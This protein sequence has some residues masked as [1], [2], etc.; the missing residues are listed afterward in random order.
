[1]FFNKAVRKHLVII[2]I[3]ISLGALI[4]YYLM[5]YDPEVRRLFT[6]VEILVSVSLGIIIAYVNYAAAM[7]LD[8]LIP[9]QSQTTNRLL[10]GVLTHFFTGLSI[11]I[12]LFY[13]YDLLVLSQ[14]N[15]VEV[16]KPMIIK[17]AI[18]WFIIVQLFSV[19]Y[20]ALYSYYSYS[21]LQIQ[22]V[23]LERK[24]IDLQLNALKSQLSPHFLFNSLNTISSLIYK[25]LN[26]A[27]TFIRRLAKMYHYTL[28]SYHTKLVSFQEELDF[29]NS[30]IYLQ[31]T[32]F[33]KVFK[34]K[35]DLPSSIN[36]TKIPPLALQMLIENA[37]KH[38][39]MSE[40]NPLTVNITFEDEHIC[41]QNNITEEPRKVPSFKI[42]LKN[43]SERYQL[44]FG[45]EII[46]ANSQS[47]IVK[48]PVI[49]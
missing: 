7:K 13:L 11:A 35:I 5:F 47:F 8:K 24:Q 44:L 16:Y 39:L 30:Y 9:W 21:S 42:G 29:V 40:K 31:E 17:F 37:V 6:I 49:R 22:R 38:N 43:I 14:I 4:S 23:K 18:L 26:K 20:F 10:I 45:K 28:N 1:M 48:I 41:V 33:E 46:I 12:A 2:I 25:D 34:C 3:G 15:F 19:V 27:E 32:R 36:E